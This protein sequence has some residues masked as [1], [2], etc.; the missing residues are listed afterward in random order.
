[1]TS[2][3]N[4]VHKMQFLQHSLCVCG[5]AHN[6]QYIRTHLEKCIIWTHLRKSNTQ[7]IKTNTTSFNTCRIQTHTDDVY[8]MAS[9]MI[10]QANE[11][12]WCVNDVLW[13]VGHH[14][15]NDAEWWY[16][17]SYDGCIWHVFLPGLLR[18]HIRAFL[19]A[20]SDVFGCQC[21]QQPF[22]P[23]DAPLLSLWSPSCHRP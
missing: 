5:G 17:M 18:L 14:I 1:M 16:M 21:Q 19:A 20:R 13:W 2:F 4:V 9:Y 12:V 22:D 3:N 7:V 23:I 10:V 8:H 15:V 11:V 6:L